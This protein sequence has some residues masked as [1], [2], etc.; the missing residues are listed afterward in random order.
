[1]L[2]GF[3][4]GLTTLTRFVALLFP[5]VVVIV[6]WWLWR[7]SKR[8]LIGL[9]GFG[10]LFMVPLAP[11]FARNY[12][13]LDHFIMGRTGGGEIY[14]TGS[15]IPW[16]GDW[17]GYL[18][19]LSEYQA[20]TPNMFDHDAAMTQRALENITAD[21]I[22]VA[23]IWIKKPLKIFFQPEGLQFLIHAGAFTPSQLLLSALVIIA[24]CGHLLLLT[25][26][27][28][29]VLRWKQ[30]RLFFIVTGS[31]LLYMVVIHLPLNG[32]PRYAV[33][34]YSLIFIASAIGLLELLNDVKTHLK[35]HVKR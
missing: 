35:T 25:L 21:P 9:A 2:G 30:A 10:L 19:P 23:G 14:W 27:A 28:L 34:F 33:P 32:V 31:L 1:M 4:L 24:F 13:V 18:W 20:A 15:Y 12:I 6:I 26:A 22:G 5:V 3:I 7:D 8:T 16:D 29:G 17:Q 11:W